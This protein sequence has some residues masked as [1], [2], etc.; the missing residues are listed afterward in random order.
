MKTLNAL[1]TEIQTALAPFDAKWKEGQIVW[2]KE[3]QKA[4][5]DYQESEEGK[6]EHKENLWAYYRKMWSIVG[7]KTYFKM[8][9]DEFVK[10]CDQT[11]KARNQRI[12][13]KIIKSGDDNTSVDSGNIVYSNDGFHGLFT[14]NTSTGNKSINI[15]TIMAGGYNIQCFHLRTLIKVK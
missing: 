15:K 8:Y 7:G 4:L 12:A 14:L 6:A 5:R 13:N 10:H 3:R 1:A 2:F 9:A 11:I